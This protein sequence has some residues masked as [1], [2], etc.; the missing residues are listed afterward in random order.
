MSILMSIAMFLVFNY[1]GAYF[2][3]YLIIYTSLIVLCVQA[4]NRKEY[5]ILNAV[6]ALGLFFGFICFHLEFICP[7]IRMIFGTYEY[8]RT[9][10]EFCSSLTLVVAAFSIG[11]PLYVLQEEIKDLNSRRDVFSKKTFYN[12]LK[13]GVAAFFVSFLICYTYTSYYHEISS[14]LTDLYTKYQ[15]S[16]FSSDYIDEKEYKPT[17]SKDGDYHTIDGSKKQIQYQGSKEQ[18]ADLKAIDDYMKEHPDF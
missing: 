11:I 9:E 17:V 14:K 5:K 13:Y 7:S 16:Q 4:E 2:M 3:S 6:A 8:S 12:W 10:R 1:S 18:K 15:M